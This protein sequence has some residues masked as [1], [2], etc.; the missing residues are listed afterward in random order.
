[1][2]FREKRKI[3]PRPSG[4]K[5]LVKN[6]IEERPARGRKAVVSKAGSVVATRTLLSAPETPEVGVDAVP[7]E[8]KTERHRKKSKTLSAAAKRK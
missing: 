8:K 4:V 5:D 1:M 3:S 6:P 2:R 7:P